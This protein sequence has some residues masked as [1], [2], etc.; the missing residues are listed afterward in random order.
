MAA[1]TDLNRR[2]RVIS[3]AHER[4]SQKLVERRRRLVDH[5]DMSPSP[6]RAV[7]FNRRRL[8]AFTSR[9]PEGR[10]RLLQRLPRRIPLINFIRRRGC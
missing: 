4:S 5:V 8:L 7:N 6:C 9:R 2:L 10:L 1:A 3:L